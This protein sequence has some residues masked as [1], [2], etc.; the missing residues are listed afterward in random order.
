MMQEKKGKEKK[1]ALK[2]IVLTPL[3]ETMGNKS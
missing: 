2:P 1:N 3:V